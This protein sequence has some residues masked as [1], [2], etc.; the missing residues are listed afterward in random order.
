[1]NGAYG[2]DIMRK[3]WVQ[4]HNTQHCFALDEKQNLLTDNGNS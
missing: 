2:A 1:M 3:E 4:I